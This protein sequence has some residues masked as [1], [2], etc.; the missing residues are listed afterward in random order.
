MNWTL[1]D[2]LVVGALLSTLV[3]G[4][5]V[6]VKFIRKPFVRILCIAAIFLVVGLIW[7]E[8]AVGIFH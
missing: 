7:V 4:I 8:G 1:F 3:L 6:S 2:F 5:V